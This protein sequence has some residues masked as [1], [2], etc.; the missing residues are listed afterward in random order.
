MD[1]TRVPK[2]AMYAA[3]V[4]WVVFIALIAMV[5]DAVIATR[6]LA[7]SMIVLGAGR[8]VLPNGIL[9]AVRG[10]WW[11]SLTLLVG[12]ALLIALSPW[13]NATLVL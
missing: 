4:V 11:D 6:M 7:G 8:A 10:R 3:M 13:G 2:P 1:D 12:G 5:L 9:P